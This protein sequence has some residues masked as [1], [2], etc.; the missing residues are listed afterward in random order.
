MTDVRQRPGDIMNIAEFV[1]HSDLILKHTCCSS[2]AGT[3]ACGRWAAPSRSKL[4]RRR[5]SIAGR[6]ARCSV[7]P[8]MICATKSSDDEHGY[9]RHMMVTDK[10]T[11]EAV[12]RGDPD[13]CAAGRAAS[14]RVGVVSHAQPSPGEVAGDASSH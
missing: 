7:S 11:L 8:H 10:M 6:C 3:I 12:D 9:E 13:A 1:F 2:F 4:V 5:H 14:G